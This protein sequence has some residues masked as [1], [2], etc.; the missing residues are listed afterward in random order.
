[1]QLGT[2]AASDR[3]G[4]QGLPDLLHHLVHRQH[5]GEQEAERRQGRLLQLSR[6][7]A[8]HI[9]RRRAVAEEEDVKVARHGLTRG[10]L[11]ADTRGDAA[12]DDGIDAARAEDQLKVGALKGA[13]SGLSKQDVA[14]VHD[15]PLVERCR[16][17]S[18]GENV[19]DQGID[20]AQDAN[21]RAVWPQHM[22]GVDDEN[23]GVT[24]RRC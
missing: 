6:R 9:R 8:G 11:A 23:A 4:A 10:R 18:L 12:D 17:R 13:V 14:R 22:A 19:L 15:E 16:L 3:N 21:I 20:L 1:M 24:A 7:G 5:L 2:R